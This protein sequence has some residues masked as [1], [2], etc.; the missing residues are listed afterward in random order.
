[1][2]IHHCVE[3]LGQA[4]NG[5]QITLRWIVQER[6]NE[7]PLTWLTSSEAEFIPVAE[8]WSRLVIEVNIGGCTKVELRLGGSGQVEESY[9]EAVFIHTKR[10]SNKGTYFRPRH[11]AIKVP[12]VKGTKTRWKDQVLTRRRESQCGWSVKG[13]LKEHI[14]DVVVPLHPQVM[15]IIMGSRRTFAH[16]TLCTLPS[17]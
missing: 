3:M 14:Q 11:A 9:S 2:F 17:G 8:V 16:H 12:E 4:D 5:L 6:T 10:T 15:W 7:G 13:T 1:M